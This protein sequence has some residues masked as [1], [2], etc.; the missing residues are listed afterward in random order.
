MKGLIDVRCRRGARRPESLFCDFTVHE[1]TSTKS[2]RG[3]IVSSTV[4]EPVAKVSCAIAQTD[5]VER[6]RF[7]QMGLD[8]S[9]VL[10]SKGSP[11]ASR[12]NELHQVKGDRRFEIQWVDNPGKWDE[13]TLYYCKELV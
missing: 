12:L 7:H 5:A 2:S 11:K 10:V 1:V 3:R 9:N 4:P 13:Y 6:E 8:V